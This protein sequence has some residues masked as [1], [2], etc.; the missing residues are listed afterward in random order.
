MRKK[1]LTKK[2]IIVTGEKHGLPYSK[3]LMAS[4]I[5]ATGLPPMEAYRVAQKVE[6]ELKAEKIFQLTIN[7]LNWR[8]AKILS[9]EVGVEFAE[10]FKKW[11]AFEKLDK[12]IILMI[13]GTTGVGKSTLAS[14]VAHRLGITRIVSTDAIREIMRMVY[15]AEVIPAL[16]VS[17][18][19]ADK[20]LRIP[21][22]P[23]AD[24]LILGFREQTSIVVQGIKA[25]VKRVITEGIN[26]VVEGVHI[27]PGYIDFIEEFEDRAVIIPLIV[28]MEDEDAHRSHFFLRE[29]DTEGR[30]PYEKYRQ[31]FERIRKI[32]EFVKGLALE[33]NIPVVNFSYLDTAVND[34]LQIVFQRVFSSS[35]ALRESIKQEGEVDVV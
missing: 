15:P 28:W 22:P 30:R 27:V 2:H 10:R 34:V 16:H 11:A 23:G 29:I 32:G 6:N 13:G 21:V 20:V 9:E 31:N 18:F 26:A 17:S 14:E 8:V 12:S 7:E 19:E 25:E 33:R 5:M 3:G 24:P 1:A 35:E 4:S